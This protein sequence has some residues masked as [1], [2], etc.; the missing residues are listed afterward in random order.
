MYTCIHVYIQ[1]GGFHCFWNPHV[2]T[3]IH[4]HIEKGGFHSFWN[5]HVYTCIHVHIQ[6]RWIPWFLESADN[7]ENFAERLSQNA[8]TIKITLVA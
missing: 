8:K 7:F 1:K 2:Y 3:C 5:P 4:V 6:K